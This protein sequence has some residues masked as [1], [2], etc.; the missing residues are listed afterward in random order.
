MREK[1]FRSATLWILRNERQ[2]SGENWVEPFEDGRI[3]KP[4]IT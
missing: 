2:E 1:I 4:I 3:T